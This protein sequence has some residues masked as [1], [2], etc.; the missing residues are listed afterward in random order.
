MKS[1]AL[2]KERTLVRV[3]PVVVP[4]LPPSRSG[5]SQSRPPLCPVPPVCV[6]VEGFV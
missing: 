6:C 1:V 3:V 2:L 5:V 4:Y